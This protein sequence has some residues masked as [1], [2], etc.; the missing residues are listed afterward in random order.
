MGDTISD[1]L[2][3]DSFI[4]GASSLIGSYLTSE[5]LDDALGAQTSGANSA[6][7][8]TWAMYNQNRADQAPWMTAGA[9]SL[10]Q[11]QALAENGFTYSDL[12]SDPSYTF[13]LNEGTAALERSA[14][15]RGKL[16]SGE[17]GKAL[18]NYA[19]SAASQEYGNAYNR[20]NNQFNQLAT[21]AGLGQTSTNSLGN[22]GTYAANSMANTTAS[23]GNATAANYLAN[24]N[25]INNSLSNASNLW[26]SYSSLWG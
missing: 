3:D 5:A 17:T 6:N 11:A 16:L 1:V 8:L 2:T 22:T 26:S 20:Y 12:Y 15:A 13:R 4:S 10:G 25:N 14:A 9:S 21:L 19:Q 7:A 23:L 24:A 18:T